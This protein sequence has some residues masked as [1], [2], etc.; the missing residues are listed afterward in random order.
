MRHL[1]LAVLCM[2]AVFSAGQQISNDQFN[3][4]YSQAGLSSVKHT[5]DTYNTDY[6]APG[7]SLGD[8]LVRYRAAGDGGWHEASSATAPIPE[9]TTNW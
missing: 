4:T 7:R 8:V 2:Q 5:S 3:L 6:I 1:L 9:F